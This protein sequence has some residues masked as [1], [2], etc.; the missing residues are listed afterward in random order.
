MIIE[1]G[2][3]PNFLTFV[4]RLREK[5][6]KTST[7]KLTRPGIEPGPAAWEVHHSSGRIKKIINNFRNISKLILSL[8]N[9]SRPQWSRDS[10]VTSHA[11]DPGSI[12]GRVNFLVEIFSGFFPNRKKNVFC[13]GSTRLRMRYVAPYYIVYATFCSCHAPKCLKTIIN[14]WVGV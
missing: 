5:S 11:A 12:H 3:G 6:G 7:R 9:T 14:T 4:L 8:S 2:F 13:T 1:H 10:I